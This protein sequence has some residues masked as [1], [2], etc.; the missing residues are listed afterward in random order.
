MWSNRGQA[1]FLS[2]MLAITFF[3]IGL[4][5]APVIINSASNGQT[6]MSCST[7]TNTSTQINCTLIDL[8]APYTIAVIFGLAGGLIGA[9]FT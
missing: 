4:A 7:D 9:R 1:I 3:L 8:V 2:L 6:T 5:V